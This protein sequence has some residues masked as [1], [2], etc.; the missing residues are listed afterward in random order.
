MK[1]IDGENHVDK[2]SLERNYPL[3]P[4]AHCRRV[5]ADARAG[6]YKNA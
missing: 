2:P 5:T 1:G 4:T 3:A 6:F